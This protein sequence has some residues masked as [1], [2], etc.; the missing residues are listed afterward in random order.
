M[1]TSTFHS[2]W[3]VGMALSLPACAISRPEPTE[4]AAWVEARRVL[5]EAKAAQRAAPE[6]PS[7]TPVTAPPKPAAVARVAQGAGTAS[8]ERFHPARTTAYFHGESDHLAY[9]R[10]SALG[11]ELTYGALRSAA[12]DWSRYP[13]G[14]RFRII[15]DH[16]DCEYRIDDYGKA[17]VGTNTIDLYKPTRR[18]MNR[19]GCRVV[20][21][22][23]LDWGC[24]EKSLR[25]MEE[26]THSPHVRRMVE[27]IQS[28]PSSG[29]HGQL[30]A[31]APREDS[32]P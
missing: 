15:G 21:I 10:K 12:A 20:V 28:R 14:T 31:V 23:V 6:Q 32:A 9:G 16:H 25:L 1:Q 7:R 4:E 19:W 30:A 18:E 8:T 3:A 17:L 5:A 11:T 26:R 2:L 29:G 27:A 22:E 24:F 13:L